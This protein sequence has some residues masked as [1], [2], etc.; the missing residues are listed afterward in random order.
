M[1]QNI[2][3]NRRV[4]SIVF[5]LL[6]NGK[7]TK[8]T[9]WANSWKSELQMTALTMREASPEIFFCGSRSMQNSLW[10]K[11]SFDDGSLLKDLSFLEAHDVWLEVIYLYYSLFLTLPAFYHVVCCMTFCCAMFQMFLWYDCCFITKEFFDSVIQLSFVF[12]CRCL[13]YSC[14]QDGD[15]WNEKRTQNSAFRSG[16]GLASR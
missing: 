11:F 4:L 6:S 8:P 2:H 3:N 7:I 1:E 10:Q 9:L 16:V 13:P 15:L 14:P 12:Y 5:P